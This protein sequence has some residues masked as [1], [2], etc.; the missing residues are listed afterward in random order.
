[1]EEE[2]RKKLN[3]KRMKGK[4]FGLSGADRIWGRAFAG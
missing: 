1:M 2:K 4:I 3:F